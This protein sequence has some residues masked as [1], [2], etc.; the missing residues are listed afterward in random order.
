[1]RRLW[2]LSIL[3]KDGRE[4]HVQEA[5]F[6]PNHSAG[7]AAESLYNDGLN[8]SREFFCEIETAFLPTW[9]TNDNSR[10]I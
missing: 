9:H 10:T 5:A 7:P 1:M 4:E 6:D 2:N 8:S 3:F